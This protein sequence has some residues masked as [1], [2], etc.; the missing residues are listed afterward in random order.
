MQKSR[1]RLAVLT[2]NYIARIDPHERFGRHAYRQPTLLSLGAAIVLRHDSRTM[3][4]SHTTHSIYILTSAQ[5][6]RNYS[7]VQYD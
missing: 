2:E 4:M 5:L 3:Y 1:E 7:S 6:S